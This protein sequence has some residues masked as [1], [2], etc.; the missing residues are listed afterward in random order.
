[1]SGTGRIIKG[2]AFGLVAIAA[3]GLFVGAPK[4]SVRAATNCWANG[5]SAKVAALGFNI[6]NCAEY[7]SCKVAGK[8]L[9]IY[10]SQERIGEPDI[11]TFEFDYSFS[12]G[13]ALWLVI[14]AYNFAFKVNFTSKAVANTLVVGVIAASVY[15]ALMLLRDATFGAIV[16]NHPVETIGKF[17]NP[18]RWT[19][20][21]IMAC[22]MSY[23]PKKGAK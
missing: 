11:L 7:P 12:L 10:R 17:D 18:V 20:V 8:E 6:H 16:V 15:F 9:R 19:L 14:M 4:G 21:V 13:I 22:I 23:L 2:A 5:V 3:L 1:M